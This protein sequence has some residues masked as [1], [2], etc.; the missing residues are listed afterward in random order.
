MNETSHVVLLNERGAVPDAEGHCGRGAVAEHAQAD[1]VP[2][3]EG[4][5]TVDVFHPSPKGRASTSTIAERAERIRT[6]NVCI[7]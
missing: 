2:G 4:E 1:R 3:P 6:A 5:G 7:S